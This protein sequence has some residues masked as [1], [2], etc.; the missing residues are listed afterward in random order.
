MKFPVSN[1][2]NGLIEIGITPECAS[3]TKRS[4]RLVNTL[5]I[6]TGCTALILAPALEYV[7]H[8]PFTL[9]GMI[10]VSG[11]A[12]SL[13]L[14]YRRRYFAASIVMLLTQT[15]AAIYFGI[16]LGQGVTIKILLSSMMITSTFVFQD[17]RARIISLLVGIAS[18]FIL[19]LNEKY[20]FMVPWF[21]ASEDYLL[22]QFLADGIICAL[23]WIV[24]NSFH[25]MLKRASEN[26][27]NFLRETNHEVNKSS[28]TLRTTLDKY[29]HDAPLTGQITMT[30]E[31][32]RGIDAAIKSVSEIVKNGLDFTK[33]EAGLSE[34]KISLFEIR[35][36]LE[37]ILREYSASATKHGVLIRINNLTGVPD[38][39]ES[40]RLKL[41][42]ILT[43]VLS[44][45]IKFSHLA[46]STDSLN[47]NQPT[48]DL[49]IKMD[50]E[51]L[52]ME[53]V[54]YGAGM[55]QKRLESIF[56]GLYVSEESGLMQGYGVGMVTTKHLVDLLGGSIKAVSIEGK[57]STFTIEIPVK[58]Q[59]LIVKKPV[60]TAHPESQ[61]KPFFMVPR[62]VLIVEDDAV[63]RSWAVHCFELLG[64]ANRMTAENAKQ[65]I[66]RARV[67]I[68]D[69]ILMDVRLPDANGLTVIKELRR[70]PDLKNI[71]IIVVSSEDSDLLR[72]EAKQAGASS[73]LLKPFNEAELKS[74]IIKAK[75]IQV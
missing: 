19:N 11:F 74:A 20:H 28:D 60:K 40:D 64:C 29:L 8:E 42:A 50:Q 24:V 54:D 30:I 22:I 66:I 48:V 9:P 53:V 70:N 56:S 61:T 16:L 41:K 51:V 1:W 49:N 4:I 33:I 39:I 63:M 68:P 38:W 32:L 26:K 73:F 2:L 72:N 17:R 14:N 27:S 47:M 44:N 7:T 13:Y 23:T 5:N 10:E 52:V 31:D 15:L 45:A 46:Q 25:R 6:V 34:I 43:N 35:F 67:E 37:E 65:G 58:V 3:D 18:M 62:S 36:L 69:M 12:F 71:S 59:S 55:N 21:F 57:G 75:E